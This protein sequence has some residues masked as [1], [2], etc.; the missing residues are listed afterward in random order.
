MLIIDVGFVSALR[1][2]IGSYQVVARRL[3]QFES[4]FLLFF[5]L[6]TKFRSSITLKYSQSV[7][8]LEI[9]GGR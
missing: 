7:R 6:R 1:D 4:S 2:Y 3:F 8:L 9:Y 5:S